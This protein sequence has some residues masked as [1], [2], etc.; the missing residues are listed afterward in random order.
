MY[1]N[2]NNFMIKWPC[3]DKRKSEKNMIYLCC[4][5]GLVIRERKKRKMF[6]WE[7]N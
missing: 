5:Y 4:C 1:Q 2:V 7:K 3:G 6:L